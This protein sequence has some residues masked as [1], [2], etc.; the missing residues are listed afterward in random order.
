MDYI[1]NLFNI[2][3]IGYIITTES[4]KYIYCKCTRDKYNYYT[5]TKKI[6]ENNALAVKLFQ[7]SC[8]NPT[9]KPLISKQ[10]YTAMT[11]YYKNA[12]YTNKDINNNILN[13]IKNKYNLTIDQDNII[14]SGTVAIVYIG[15]KSSFNAVDISLYKVFQLGLSLNPPISN[16]VS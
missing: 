9:V 2:F 1:Y 12:H 8:N 3:N 11:T 4:I 15:T 6:V 14:N 5:L 16:G 13:Y 7:Y 10:L